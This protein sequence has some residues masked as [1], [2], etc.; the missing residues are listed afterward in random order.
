LQFRWSAICQDNLARSNVVI[1]LSSTTVNGPVKLG[2]SDFIRAASLI[3][4]A[5]VG[6]RTAVLKAALPLALAAVI[7]PTAFAAERGRAEIFDLP[8]QPLGNAL[9][10]FS[11]KT[12][13]FAAYDAKLVGGRVSSLVK[14][15]L[16]PAAAL[17]VL[18]AA[19]GLEADYT[20]ENAFV[21]V[22]PLALRQ[23]R[24][25]P[26]QIGQAGL[27]PLTASERRYS[28][29]LQHSVQSALCADPRTRRGDYRAAVRFRVDGRGTLQAVKLLGSTGDPDRDAAIVAVAGRTSV[30]EPPP[31]GMQQ[32]FAVVVLPRDAGGGAD[33]SGL[34]MRPL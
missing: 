27:S 20:A 3:E 4:R 33:C 10:A 8:S 23:V 32:P 13:M 1:L 9:E 34:A 19:S 14:G 28:A 15:E 30:D 22:Q 2:H 24:R 17:S 25:D 31:A 29:H 7:C 6:Y 18:L 26:K 12:G 11:A 5:C 16:T 21:I